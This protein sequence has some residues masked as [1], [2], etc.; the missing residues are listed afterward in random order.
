MS[1]GSVP[2]LG[3]VA[4][5]NCPGKP[6]GVY[7]HTVITTACFAALKSIVHK[8]RLKSVVHK[9]KNLK[10]ALNLKLFKT[11]LKIVRKNL[12]YSELKSGYVFTVCVAGSSLA[13]TCHTTSGPP[14]A[15][16]HT[17]TSLR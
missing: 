3:S 15:N 8:A 2:F 14:A 17:Q 12:N 13:R 9:A 16:L 11:V 6:Q 10:T 1:V 7:Q 4:M 5:R